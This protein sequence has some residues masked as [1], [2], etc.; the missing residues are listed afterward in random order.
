MGLDIYLYRY[1][2]PR[3]QIEKEDKAWDAISSKIFHKH[4]DPVEKARG[5][6]ADLTDAERKAW[7]KEL[8]RA[9]EE[10]GRVGEWH[11]NPHNPK[12]NI[13][14]A[15]YPEH[16]FKIGYF[17]SSYNSG[18]I[19]HILEDRVGET[20]Y[21]LLDVNHDEYVQQPDWEDVI[22]NC[23]R[24]IAAFRQSVKEN[25]YHIIEVDSI[26]EQSNLPGNI[27]EALKIAQKVLC[28]DKHGF[29]SFTNGNGFWSINGLE[30]FGVI[31]GYRKDFLQGPVT[32]LVTKST[33]K[34]GDEPYQWYINAIEIVKETAQWVLKQENP[35]K[36]YLHVSG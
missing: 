36:Y 19:N 8:A 35:E 24:V 18:G 9:A 26:L 10:Y 20:L 25:P 5:K 34:K 33:E 4:F 15:L 17:R 7:K 27:P 14:S 30:V 1:D 29:D 28:A 22:K 12:V 11:D 16:M 3:K 31:P 6:D 32:F 2:K 23:D 21:S 13:D